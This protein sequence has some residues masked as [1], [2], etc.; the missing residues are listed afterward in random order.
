MNQ[1][2]HIDPGTSN[3]FALAVTK[4]RLLIIATLPS[5]SNDL[6]IG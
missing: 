1:R 3:M 5:A 4:N 6:L 2:E